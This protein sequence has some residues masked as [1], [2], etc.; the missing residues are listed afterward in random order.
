MFERSFEKIIATGLIIKIISNSNQ[1]RV[2]TPNKTTNRDED[3]PYRAAVISVSSHRN[4]AASW[5]IV[6][7]SYLVQNMAAACSVSFRVNRDLLLRSE[8]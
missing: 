8:I 1:T 5:K 2:Y 4:V 3:G 6:K 7:G